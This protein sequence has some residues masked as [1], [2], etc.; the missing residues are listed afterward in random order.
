MKHFS[1]LKELPYFVLLMLKKTN[2]KYV[3]ILCLRNT[4]VICFGFLIKLE[5]VATCF[6]QKWI[7]SNAM[8]FIL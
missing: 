8:T 3:D 7:A 2:L 1:I 4:I 5:F 6:S